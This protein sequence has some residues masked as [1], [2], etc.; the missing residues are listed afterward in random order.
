M[1]S[2]VRFRLYTLYLTAIIRSLIAQLVEHEMHILEVPG[3]DPGRGRLILADINISVL[4]MSW[5]EREDSSGGD[6]LNC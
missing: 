6:N 5:G 1:Y 3:S 2:R 4:A